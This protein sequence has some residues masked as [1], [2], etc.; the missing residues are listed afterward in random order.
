MK[1]LIQRVDEASVKVDGQEV[2]R[3]GRGVLTLLGVQ[4]GDDEAKARKLIKK[5]CDLRI[6][7]DSADKMNLSLKDIGASHLIV[8]QFTLVADCSSGRRPSFIEAE[9]PEIARH[10]YEIALEES[11]NLSVPTFS[12]VFQADMK[13]S[14]INSGPVTFILEA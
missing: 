3:I 14:L 8:S 5:I 1:A 6:F 12:G 9:V 7:E 10:L 2:S 13:I 4:K 11:R